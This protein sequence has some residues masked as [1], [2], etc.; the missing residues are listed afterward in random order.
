MDG[1][2]ERFNL[3]ATMNTTIRNLFPFM[4]T[5]FKLAFLLPFSPSFYLSMAKSR[6]KNCRSFLDCEV[7]LAV[8]GFETGGSHAD[9]NSNVDLR[10]AHFR[11]ALKILHFFTL[12]R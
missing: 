3:I 9:L 8:H 10:L 11:K 6:K 7:L 5:V 4:A 1:E 12:G 2:R